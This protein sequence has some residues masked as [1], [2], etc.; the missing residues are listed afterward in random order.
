MRG[1]TTLEVMKGHQHTSGPNAMA[2]AAITAGS[3]S[4]EGAGLTQQGAGPDPVGSGRPARGGW[5]EQWK[6]LLGIDSFMA[7]ALHGSRADEVM[8][9]RREN[10]F[11][12]GMITNLRDF[13]GDP[14]PQCGRRHN[15]EAMLGGE[16]V[17]YT[18]M[19][20]VPSRTNMRRGGDGGVN[21]YSVD[22]E[23]RV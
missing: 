5:F 16:R 11:N 3:T 17:S 8:R 12:R 2:T 22:T 10:P 6:K 4:L 23:D 1:Q 21:Y 20:D 15:G 13:F 14:A 19:Y 18:G 9:R 7:T